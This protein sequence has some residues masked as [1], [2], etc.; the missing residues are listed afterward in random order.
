M[1]C[2][3]AMLTI[4][5]LLRVSVLCQVT[6]HRKVQLQFG[7]AHRDTQKVQRISARSYK[8]SASRRFITTPG[9]FT[10]KLQQDQVIF[11]SRHFQYITEA[12]VM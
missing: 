12:D 1:C 3:Y 11:S 9:W 5:R 4:S 8:S 10:I 2:F 7:S 6:T